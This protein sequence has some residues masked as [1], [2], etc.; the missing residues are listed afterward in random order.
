MSGPR[1]INRDEIEKIFEETT[2]GDF[3]ARWMNEWQIG[4][5]HLHRMRRTA[6]AS[7]MEKVG[8]EW[9]KLF[10]GG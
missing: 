8:H 5:V 9:R 2:R 10:G 1:V 4:M 3:A 7:L 6:Q